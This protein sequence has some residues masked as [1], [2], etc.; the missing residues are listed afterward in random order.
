MQRIEFKSTMLFV[1]RVFIG[2]I[3]LYHGIPKLL[4]IS[5]TMSFFSSIGLP[6]FLAVVV[7][8]VE[9]VAGLA[10]VVGFRTQLA[11]Y[12]LTV[13]IAGALITAQIPGLSMERG[14]FGLF[15]A[16]I[17]RDILILIGLLSVVANGPGCWALNKKH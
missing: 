14:F 16:G 8:I 13:I 5:G 11:A 2:L 17:E 15:G 7:G 4:N 10:L 6:G 9:I 1:L 3:F 12:A